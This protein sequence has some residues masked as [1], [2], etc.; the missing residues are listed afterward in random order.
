MERNVYQN[1]STMS[2]IVD[3][4]EGSMY[5]IWKTWG[6]NPTY[7]NTLFIR[8]G[9]TGWKYL[10]LS[11]V[12]N[13]LHRRRKKDRWKDSTLKFRKFAKDEWRSWFPYLS[14]DYSYFFMALPVYIK[15]Q[16][17]SRK[18]VIPSREEIGYGVISGFC[19]TYV[20]VHSDFQ[21]L[22]YPN[23][24]HKRDFVSQLQLP[25]ANI[26]LFKMI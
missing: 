3:I 25:L 11:P 13:I 18:S 5:L 6:T 8:L 10:S 20:R 7:G 2:I 23:K 26:Q 12:K 22:F 1:L 17:A 16:K 24:L 19:L 14:L 9:K 21:A 15:T 4:G